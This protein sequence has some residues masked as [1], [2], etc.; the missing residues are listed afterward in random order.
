MRGYDSSLG[1]GHGSVHA[2][3]GT[4]LQCWVPP[5]KSRSEPSAEIG[6]G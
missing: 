2:E 4:A 5:K 3:V 6:V 1:V